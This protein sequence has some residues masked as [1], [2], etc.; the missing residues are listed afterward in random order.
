MEK[1]SYVRLVLDEPVSVKSKGD[2]D[3]KPMVYLFASR[4]SG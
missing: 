4:K 3:L 1:E 2:R